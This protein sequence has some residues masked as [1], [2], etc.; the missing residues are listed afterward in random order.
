M[1]RDQKKELERLEKA[2]LEQAEPEET[3]EEPEFAQEETEYIQEDEPEYT[4]YNNDATDVDPEEF[5]D[6][7]YDPPK[8]RPMGLLAV[9]FF[10]ITA[11]FFFLVWFML[12]I[13]GFLG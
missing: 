13:G 2:L 5:G 7:V 8:K 6:A 3:Q 1:F 12:K 9:A 10:L 4:I 11:T